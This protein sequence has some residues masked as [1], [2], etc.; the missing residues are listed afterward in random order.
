M[1]ACEEVLGPKKCHHKDWIS[2][3][4]LSKIRVREEKKAAVHSSRT[5]A[6]KFKAQREYTISNKNTK[7]SIPSR[8]DKKNYTDGLAEVAK[9]A[10]RAGNLKGLYDTTKKLAGKFRT[11]ESPGKD[12]AGGQ[13]VGEE[14][15]RKRRGER[16]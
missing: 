2:A 8:A 13:I 7:K 9:L 15:Q 11:P 10:G 16:F 5:R 1:S 6:E 4:T 14:Q 12:K 3:E